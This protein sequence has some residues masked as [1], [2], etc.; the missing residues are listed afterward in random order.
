MSEY[1][2]SI[3]GQEENLCLFENA[4]EVWFW[5]MKSLEAREDGAHC[6]NARGD[7]VR[8]CEPNDIYMVISR[9]HRTRRLLIDHI[10]VLAHY[11]KRGHAPV[12]N[13]PSEQKAF[14]LWRE[15]MAVLQ[16]VFSRKQILRPSL[17][18]VG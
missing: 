7:K 1:V 16:D 13:R 9:L 5:F 17:S 2:D 11:G 4:Q 10:R 3:S 15:A 12:L 6:A 8:P 14:Y 18:V